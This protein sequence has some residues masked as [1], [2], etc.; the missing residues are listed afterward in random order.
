LTPQSLAAVDAAVDEHGGEAKTLYEKGRAFSAA[1]IDKYDRDLAAAPDGITAARLKVEK[2]QLN[3]Y[4]RFPFDFAAKQVLD[5][6]D[7]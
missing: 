5:G 2:R 7:Q 4:A 1:V 3:R 6:L